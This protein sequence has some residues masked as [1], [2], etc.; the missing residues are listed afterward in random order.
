MRR[1]QTTFFTRALKSWCLF[2]LL[3]MVLP[4]VRS[5]DTSDGDAVG[6]NIEEI[7]EQEQE[8][9]VGEQIWAHNLITDVKSKTA[10]THEAP[11]ISV[12]TEVIN[13]RQGYEVQNGLDSFNSNFIYRLGDSEFQVALDMF[14]EREENVMYLN[15]AL[16]YRYNFIRTRSGM[17]WGIMPEVS[18]PPSHKL[19]ADNVNP[20][21]SLPLDIFLPSGFMMGLKTVVQRA[22]D[23]DYMRW[24][25]NYL[26]TIYIG[27]QIYESLSG[28]LEFDDERS[29]EAHQE[30]WNSGTFTLR[31]QLLGSMQVE[32]TSSIQG[33]T[34]E[35]PVYEHALGVLLIF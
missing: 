8:E 32:L 1:N 6:F 20:G 9:Y 30:P 27:H 17:A 7:Q 12:W 19:Q 3:L 11:S 29:D 4:E 28:Y 18:L 13:Y 21:I 23:W 14:N 31:Q 10:Y 25:T 15:T 26:T 35:L 2:F 22:R 5:E 24:K 16:R 33:L 34:A